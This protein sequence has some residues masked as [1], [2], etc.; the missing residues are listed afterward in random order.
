MNLRA[1]RRHWDAF[2][3]RDAFWAVLT[4][5]DKTGNR[6]EADEFFR[7][8]ADEIR[9]VL[10]YLAG[11]G[12]DPPRGRALDFG[13]GVGRLTQALAGHFEEAVGVDIAPSMIELARSHDRTGRCRFVLNDG[14]SLRDLV[15][16]SFDFVY[17]NIVLQHIEPRHTR[18]YLAEMLRV[19]RPGGILL[20]QLPAEPL[21]AARHGLKRFVPP[22]VLRACRWLR[23]LR[24]FPRM[25]G[26]GIP[27]DEVLGILTEAG[28]TVVDVVSDASTGPAWRGFRYCVTKAAAPSR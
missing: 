10:A 1:L 14:D 12:V 8:G 25:E 23:R 2:A 21:A 19:L 17:S 11:L 18:R 24:E 28:G 7:T 5:P 15:S 4:D 6:W 9:S 13:C 3:R 26:Y 27:R 20:F 22:P 16:G